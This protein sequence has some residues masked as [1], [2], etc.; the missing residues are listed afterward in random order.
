[1]LAAVLCTIFKCGQEVNA[2][3]DEDN[4]ANRFIIMFY[5]QPFVIIIKTL[6]ETDTTVM[7]ISKLAQ[8]LSF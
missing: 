7:L 8:T 4:W 1:M 3:V 2:S 5:V 6:L